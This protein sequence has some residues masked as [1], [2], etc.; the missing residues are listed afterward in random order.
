MKRLAAPPEEWNC[1]IL[2]SRFPRN[3]RPREERFELPLD[4]AVE[5]WGQE[6]APLAP[7]SVLVT[8]NYAG[9]DI[10]TRVFM[11]GKFCLPCSRCLA[12]TSIA[13]EGDMRYLF[14]LRNLGGDEGDGAPDGGVDV[15]EVDKFQAELE[16][17]PYVWETL[18][19]NLPEGVLCRADCL[20]L[21]PVCGG[22]KNARECGCSVEGIDPRMRELESFL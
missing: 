12:E 20:G 15:I 17:A 10:M 3:G 22:D 6:Y 11:S 13:I 2:L 4:G 5:Y 19:L 18:I 9:D 1:G 21:C 7:L 16:M 8:A 14:T